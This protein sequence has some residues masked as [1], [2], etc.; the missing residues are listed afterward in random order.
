LRI[1]LFF[2]TL[3]NEE[4][5]NVHNKIDSYMLSLGYGSH[6]YQVEF[7]DEAYQIQSIK[8]PPVPGL[9]LV[10]RTRMAE[11][12]IPIITAQPVTIEKNGVV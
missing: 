8:M 5:N 4:Q 7:S 1:V 10:V 9:T 12:F 3:S 2:R 11:H 6:C